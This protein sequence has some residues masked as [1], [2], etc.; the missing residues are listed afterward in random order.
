V[1][2]EHG[3]LYDSSVIKGF[4]TAVTTSDMVLY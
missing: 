1:I 4:L 3:L 2:K